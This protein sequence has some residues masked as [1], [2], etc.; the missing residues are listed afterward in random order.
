MRRVRLEEEGT[1]PRVPQRALGKARLCHE[2]DCS[3]PLSPVHTCCGYSPGNG[4][5]LSAMMVTLLVVLFAILECL[6]HN[7]LC[8]ILA[9]P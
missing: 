9:A 2:A 4:T 8:I 3:V 5:E 1:S 6:F 7:A